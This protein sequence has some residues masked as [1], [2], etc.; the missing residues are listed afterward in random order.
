[1]FRKLKLGSKMIISFLMVGAI[2]FGIVGLVSLQKASSALEKQAF[3]QLEA[4][5]TLKKS[6]SKIILTRSK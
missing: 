4:V 1:M 3:S 2:P 5:Q 6:S